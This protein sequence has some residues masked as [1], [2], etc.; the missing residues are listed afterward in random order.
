MAVLS[1]T[2]QFSTVVY[3]NQFRPMTT[4]RIAAA[5]LTA[6]V[7]VSSSCDKGLEPSNE[8]SGFS[9]VIHFKNWPPPDSV[10]EL[11]LVAFEK[12]PSDTASIV[13][14]LFSGEAVL[15]PP[16]GA[17]GFPKF[18]DSIEYVF[19]NA[20]AV[21]KVTKYDYVVVAWRYGTNFFADWR[22]A[23]VYTTNPGSFDPA[24][25]LVLLHRITPDIDIE[26]D[27]YNPPPRPWQ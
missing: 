3:R 5:L 19:D 18:V 16:V 20:G 25:V 22:P 10:L 7:F 11:R 1:F 26:V 23:G 17:T 15:Y 8:P 6:L 2:R 9:G 12:Y 27:F 13:E 24:P 21:I 14:A 4:S